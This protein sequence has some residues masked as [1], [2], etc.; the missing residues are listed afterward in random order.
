MI[1]T[2]QRATLILALLFVSSAFGEVILSRR[3]Y[4]EH[5]AS[6]QQ[7][8]IWNP[9]DGV[10]KALTHSPRDHYY[11]ICDGRLIKLASPSRDVPTT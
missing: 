11:P 7:I 3:V 10:F 2:P 6:C 9:A 4:K 5:G 8:W 1:T